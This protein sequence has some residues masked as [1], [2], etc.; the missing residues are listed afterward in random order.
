VS[1]AWEDGRQEEEE[2]DVGDRWMAFGDGRGC[3]HLRRRLW[4]ELCGRTVLEEALD[5]LL[6]RIL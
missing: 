4:I 6:D 2:E 3:S 5:L 1:S